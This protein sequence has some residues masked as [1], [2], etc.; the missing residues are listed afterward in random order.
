[1]PWRHV[2]E[3]RCISI[4][5]N[6]GAR[7]RWMASFTALSLYPRENCRQYPL[8]RWLGGPLSRSGRCGVQYGGDY[9]F[10]KKFCE[11]P[12][13]YFP[14]Y[15]TGHIGNDASKNSSIVACVF[16]AAVT[17]LPSRCLATIGGF[18][19]SRCLAMMAGYLQTRCLVTIRGY[20]YRHTDWWE[21]LFT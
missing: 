17:F 9:I 21:V 18:L 2:G 8:V 14:W 16:V 4:I 10:N 15:G 3:W 11:E 20:T 19:L 5:L 13:S 1:M 7:R 6:L 12:I